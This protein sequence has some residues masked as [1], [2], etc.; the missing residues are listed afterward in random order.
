MQRRTESDDL[1]LG[2]RTGERKGHSGEGAQ[3]RRLSCSL[4][5]S[6]A[7]AREGVRATQALQPRAR[8]EAYAG[9]GAPIVCRKPLAA[10]SFCRAID[11][12][13]VSWQLAGSRGVLRL[14]RPAGHLRRFGAT[15]C[16]RSATL[17]WP[18]AHLPTEPSPS[19]AHCTRPGPRH[20]PVPCHRPDLT[21]TDEAPR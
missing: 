8:H 13:E 1:L 7:C 14:R 5:A 4:R 2:M 18:C 12:K 20:R 11:D 21:V 10:C 17:S 9:P 6:A 19:M 15:S 3:T 16:T